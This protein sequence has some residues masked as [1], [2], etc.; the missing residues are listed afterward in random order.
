[1]GTIRLVCEGSSDDTFGVYGGG[2]DADHDNCANGKPIAFRVRAGD[3]SLIVVGQ[4]A[5]GECAGW[6][7]G[8]APDGEDDTPIPQWR[9]WFERSDRAYSPALVIEAPLGATVEYIR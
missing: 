1:M 6:L 8:I 7:I 3:E 2:L 9:M 5:P 4:Y